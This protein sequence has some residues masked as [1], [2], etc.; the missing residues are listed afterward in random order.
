M[1]K[2]LRFKQAV[3]W[4][5]GGMGM[6]IHYRRNY[7]FVLVA[8]RPGKI[9]WNGGKTT[10]NVFRLPKIIPSARQHPTEKPVGLAE[11]FIRLHSNPGEVVLDPFA[12]HGST[13]VAAKRLGRRYI[14]VEIVPEYCEV[15]REQVA[16]TTP[17][18]FVE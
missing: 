12:G 5:K 16:N 2:Y 11:H 3:I 6:G 15:A 1:D 7:E 4:D 10:P 14:G 18:L 13:A 17:P 9:T 8:N